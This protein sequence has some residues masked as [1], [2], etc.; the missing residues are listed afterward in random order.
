MALYDAVK[1]GIE[2]VFIVFHLSVVLCILNERWQKNHKFASA[3]Y[4]L[5]ILQTFFDMIF[6]LTV[7]TLNWALIGKFCSI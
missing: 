2:A 3:F 7:R 1:A 6:V 4:T 5:Y